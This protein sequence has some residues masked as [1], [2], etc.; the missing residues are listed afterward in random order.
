M[1]NCTTLHGKLEWNK[2]CNKDIIIMEIILLL[3]SIIY[4]TR[5][6]FVFNIKNSYYVKLCRHVV[7]CMTVKFKVPKLRPLSTVQHY[8]QGFVC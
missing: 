8:E 7:L 6:I 3:L 1:Y 2:N 5:A 4:Y